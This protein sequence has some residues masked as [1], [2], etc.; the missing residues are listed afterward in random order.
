M[1]ATRRPS[2]TGLRREAAGCTRCPLYE[3]AIQT[4]FGE[5]RA[6]GL[7]LVGEH[8]GDQ[9]DLAGRPFV[10]SEGSGQAKAASA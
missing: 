4:V 2:L 6:G 1:V 10:G 8:A 7:M 9:E 3:S 5:G